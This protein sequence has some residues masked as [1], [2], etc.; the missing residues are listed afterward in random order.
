VRLTPARLLRLYPGLW[1][2][3]YGQEFVALLE[4]TP[5]T[6]AVIID[7]V[8]SAAREWLTRTRVGRLILGP[9]VA[10]AATICS[11][12]LAAVSPEWISFSSLSLLTLTQFTTLIVG[13]I[14]IILKTRRRNRFEWLGLR[15]Q[16]IALFLSSVWANWMLL[17]FAQ[18]ADRD[19]STMWYQSAFFVTLM[20]ILLLN[21]DRSREPFWPWPPPWWL[22]IN[23]DRY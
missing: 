22:R 20:L 3:R 19:L 12:A 9:A 7:I 13:L 5:L 11:G 1:R 4:S 18:N 21:V 14:L 16:T 6:R 17:E 23:S 15:W 2:L 10:G 8:R